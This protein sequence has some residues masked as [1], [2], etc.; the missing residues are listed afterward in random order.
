M[1]AQQLPSHQISSIS[2]GLNACSNPNVAAKP[3]VATRTATATSEI[4][5]ANG[6]YDRTGD[7]DD[8]YYDSLQT[9]RSKAW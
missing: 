4:S 9:G 7:N 6:I 2:R 1:S 3:G 8:I 5:D